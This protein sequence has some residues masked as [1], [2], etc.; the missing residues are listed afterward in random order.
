MSCPLSPGVL[1][2]D[3]HVDLETIQIKWWSVVMQ[4]VQGQAIYSFQYQF[5]GY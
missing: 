5:P 1:I 3:N 2:D 4:R